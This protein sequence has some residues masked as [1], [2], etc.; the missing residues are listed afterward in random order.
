MPR[1]LISP[2]VTA[3]HD[4]N[5]PPVDK[6]SRAHLM[7]E[8]LRT[9]LSA[10]SPGERA[11]I[12]HQATERAEEQGLVLR[13]YEEGQVV[14][15]KLPFTTVPAFMDKETMDGHA[16][17]VQQVYEAMLKVEDLALSGTESGNEVLST[18]TKG[19]DEDQ[20]EM[21]HRAKGRLPQSARN[22]NSR[23][24]TFI[25]GDEMDIFEVNNVN[26][27]GFTM[28]KGLAE[29]GLEVLDNA[30]IDL[31]DASFRDIAAQRHTTAAH[32]G[33]AMLQREFTS[34]PGNEGKQ[35]QRIGIVYE[36]GAPTD[37][38]ED[39]AFINRSEMPTL[40]KFFKEQGGGKIEVYTG[41]PTEVAA[42]DGKM[43]I[44]D[45]EI[46]VLWRNAVD[47]PKALHNPDARGFVEVISHPGKYPVLND[48]SSQIIGSKATLSLLFD[49]RV[50]DEIGMTP[51]EAAAVERSV[52]FSFIPDEN[53]LLINGQ[54]KMTAEEYLMKYRNNFV[55]KP[56]SG[57]HGIGV[58]FGPNGGQA[59]DEAVHEAVESGTFLA[60]RYIPYERIH[61]P[62]LELGPDGTLD[63][64]TY[65]RDTNI[66]KIGPR[67]T[68]SSI[69]RIVPPDPDG[70]LK[71][72]N[73][74]AGG[75]LQATFLA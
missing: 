31:Q 28:H 33:F 3:H 53:V 16:Q 59:W 56:T 69:S 60:Q 39:I 41:D 57:T 73:V 9:K 18:I 52:P 20:V 72:L 36:H 7:Q 71:I 11:D 55:L 29:V 24:D 62:V 23:A 65:L 21:L 75:G 32:Q 44:G 51:E 45:K 50:R 66:H 8:T 34:R 38:E 37:G 25:Q 13:P 42:E 15:Q 26:P 43:S 1:E 48:E 17:D 4:S 58:V 40:S 61:V 35:V 49:K 22:R 6:N 5:R 10:K 19:M 27:E 74:A 63:H 68:G 64:S 67:T 46:D 14:Q 2:D 54:E 47:I 70:K 12:Y 30:G